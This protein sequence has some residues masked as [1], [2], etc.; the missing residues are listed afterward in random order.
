MYQ[1][2][3]L[4]SCLEKRGEDGESE[5]E[6]AQLIR[7]FFDSLGF[8]EIAEQECHLSFLPEI[9]KMVLIFSPK[10]PKHLCEALQGRVTDHCA[11][12][13]SCLELKSGIEL[14]S[15][16]YCELSLTGVKN[17]EE[18]AELIKAIYPQQRRCSVM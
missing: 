4:R 5:R 2:G 13:G 9:E 16:Q 15:L 7:Q 18:M 12:K 14:T 3:L 11:I 6:E 10:V 1:F 8:T 17:K